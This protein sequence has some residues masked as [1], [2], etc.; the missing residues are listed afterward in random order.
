MLRI[1]DRYKELG[2]QGSHYELSYWL[3]KEDP[4]EADNIIIQCFLQSIEKLAGCRDIKSIVSFIETT[5][6]NKILDEV[7]SRR[8]KMEREILTS[9]HLDCQLLYLGNEIESVNGRN[10][11]LELDGAL[12]PTF[13]ASPPNYDAGQ[14][15]RQYIAN[16]LCS[17]RPWRWK[18]KDAN[19]RE[20]KFVR[21][22]ADR[23]NTTPRRVR[24]LLQEE[25]ERFLAA[26]KHGVYKTPAD[27]I[28]KHRNLAYGIFK[29][30]NHVKIPFPF[31]QMYRFIQMDFKP[32]K[33]LKNIGNKEDWRGCSLDLAD[34][35]RFK[36]ESERNGREIMFSLFD[37]YLK[38]S[39][40]DYENKAK[41]YIQWAVDSL[42]RQ[43]L[44]S[45][46]SG[47][48]GDSDT[49]HLT[50]EV[51][52]NAGLGILTERGYRKGSTHLSDHQVE[53]QLPPH[54]K[55]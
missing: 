53:G 11:L 37:Y 13:E 25:T 40:L 2:W 28:R 18:W 10:E 45:S 32:K 36:L 12:L 16:L 8:S 42:I 27:L 33:L 21:H 39:D 6:W 38:E 35:L 15:L 7:D 9:P 20:K 52:S 49:V 30:E 3:V 31:E 14:E 29:R 17:S 41:L 24:Q 55:G 48:L 54:Q 34:E 50:R 46:A 1:P 43:G 51:P 47:F 4:D 26:L 5:L 44:L 19:G 23:F 22:T